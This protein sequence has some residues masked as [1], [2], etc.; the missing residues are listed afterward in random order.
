MPTACET[1]LRATDGPCPRHPYAD[2]LNL[3]R[4]DDREWLAMMRS[5]RRQTRIRWG[6]LAVLVAELAVVAGHLNNIGMP[7]P[8]QVLVLSAVP[9]LT[10]VCFGIY[11]GRK[12]RPLQTSDTLEDVPLT[13][14]ETPVDTGE[15]SQQLRSARRDRRTERANRNER[16]AKSSRVSAG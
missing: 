4:H 8:V 15:M 3:A 16:I 1:C 9:L 10:L 5:Q 14:P 7:D 11:Q 2:Q 13:L 12:E 6:M